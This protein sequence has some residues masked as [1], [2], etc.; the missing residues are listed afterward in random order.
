[1]HRPK[2]LAQDGLEVKLLG[3]RPGPVRTD[4]RVEPNLAAYQ[5]LLAGMA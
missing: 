1:M 2:E 3:D 5:K 4:I